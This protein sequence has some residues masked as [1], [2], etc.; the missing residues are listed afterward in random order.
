MKT[1]T[2]KPLGGPSTLAFR[3]VTP[4]D[5]VKAQDAHLKDAVANGDATHADA[6]SAM[7]GRWRHPVSV[8]RWHQKAKSDFA[9]LAE[10]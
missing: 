1:M 9:S 4:D 2:C 5:I 3:G 10:D 8:V 7:T 6:S